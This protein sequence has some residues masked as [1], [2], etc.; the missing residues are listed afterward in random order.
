M[1]LIKQQLQKMIEEELR[2]IQSEANTW[3]TRNTKAL[4]GRNVHAAV[5]KEKLAEIQ[6][7]VDQS[8]NA[9]QGALEMAGD[10]EAKG[11]NVHIGEFNTALSTTR[12]R[13]KKAHGLMGKLMDL[14]AGNPE[15][16]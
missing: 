1:K 14:V 6:G 7:V 2:H 13:L 16:R 3:E 11:G 4:G 15:K 8:A 10:A 9:F 12:E 5:L